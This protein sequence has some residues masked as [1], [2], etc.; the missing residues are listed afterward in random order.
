[1]T[2]QSDPYVRH[3]GERPRSR[4]VVDEPLLTV[5]ASEPNWQMLC[6][7]CS[8]AVLQVEPPEQFSRQKLIEQRRRREGR[9]LSRRRESA[10]SLARALGPLVDRLHPAW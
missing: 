1:M 5:P 9:Y 6:R 8:R 2:R 10:A 7:E 4:V 3:H